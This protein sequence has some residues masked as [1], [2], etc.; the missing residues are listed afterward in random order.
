MS[1]ISLI[2]ALAIEQWQPFTGR[3]HVYRA[4]GNWSQYVEQHFN[5]GA[6][7]H[8]V[9]GWM[10]VVLPLA[11][12]SLVVYWLAVSVH[13][14][15]AVAVNVLA[16]Y[17][18]L[19]FR[20]ASHF[21]TDI[22]TALKED[23]LVDARQLLAEW[24]G[25]DYSA[26]GASAIARLTIEGALI[27]SHRYVFGA[28]FWFVLLPGPAGAVLYRL[29]AYVGHEWGDS[30]V[31]EMRVFG[32]FARRAFRVIDWLPARLTA[33][34][35]AVVGDFEDAVACWRSQAA[36]WADPTIGVVLAAGAGA[37]GVRLGM[38]VEVSGEIEQRPEMGLGDD[39]DTGHLDSTIGL[40]WRALV[41]W[42]AMLAI[43]SLAQA[44][45]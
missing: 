45:S 12:V 11:I 35:F 9:V 17:A 19:G 23:R 2:L 28:L 36:S 29:A 8:G 7:Q 14:L 15:L 26:L 16:L 27:G 4:I 38:P 33:I 41:L 6:F 40:V 10:L 24:R 31:P 44:I 3:R 39:A 30:Q 1:L 22:H 5:A 37:I 25:G 21:F 42:V 32:E 18:T 20:Q 13:P 43:I 34:A